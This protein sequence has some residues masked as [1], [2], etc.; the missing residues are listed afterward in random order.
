MWVKPSAF[1]HPRPTRGI[2]QRQCHNH[3]TMTVV[4]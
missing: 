1:L 2:Q 4:N 3:L